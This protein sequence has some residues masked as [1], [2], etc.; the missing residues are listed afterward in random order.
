MTLSTSKRA[1]PGPGP[2]QWPARWP[3]L[4]RTVGTAFGS[5]LALTL[6]TCGC[7]F[8]ALAGPALSLHTRTQA[9][10]QTLAGFPGTTKTVQVSSTLDQVAGALQGGGQ[11]GQPGPA[12]GESALSQS[13]SDIARGLAATPLPLAGGDW[14]GLNTNPL[15]ITA[16]AARS[17][18]AQAPPKME[19]VYR[20][21]F[22][23]YAQLVAGSYS[24]SQ[25]PAGTVAVAATVPTAARFGL[26]PGSR[27]TLNTKS[28]PATIFVTAIVRVRAGGST[29][30]QQDT[31]IVQPSLQQ[32]TLNSPAY[33]LGGVIADP[34]Q[35][36]A[37]QNAFGAIGLEM[38]WEFPLD[39]SGVNA[40]QA[41]GL[42]QA[43]NH[44][45]TTNPTLTALAPAAS[46]LT[47]TSPLIQD[48]ALFLGTQAAVQTVLLIL[49][50]SLI[51]V[52]A[53][54]ILLAARMIV[55]RRE[56]ELT[57][58]RSRGGSLWQVAGLMLRGAVVA[59][60]PGVLVG[61]AL[62]IALVPGGAATAGWPLAAIAIAA[63]LGGP[64]LIAV[65]Q[66]RRPAPA[67]NPARIT[68]AET[69]R[70]AGPA[71]PWR[72][73]VIEVT[74]VA[75]SVAGLVVLRN[76]GV[77][78]G[79]G[80]DLYLTITPVLVAIP[81]VV[82]MVRLYPL[83]IRGLLALS[84]RGAGATGFVA[85]SRAAKSSLT[86]ALPAFALVLALSLATFAGMVNQG[87]SR[88]EVTASWHATGAD[89]LIQPA[90]D[91]VIGP[92]AV[93]AISAVPGV[94]HATEVWATNWFTL[95]GQQVTVIAVDPASYAA[96]V[97]DT[98]FSAFPARKIGQAAPRS[99]VAFGAT[100]PV[101]ASPPALAVLGQGAGQLNS[102]SA[103]G[104]LT[105]RVA[106]VLGD[107]PALPSGGPF[108]VMPL[109]SLPGP[110]GAA[111]PN[112]ILVTGSAI[113]HA[114]LT[115]V[116]NRMIPDNA[117]T[118][119]T[120]VLAALASSPLQHGAGL[121]ITLIIVAAAALGLF[122]VILGL[123]LGSAERGLTL[124]RLTVMGHDRT[125]G[126]VMAEAMPAVIAAVIAGAVCGVV[127]PRVIASAI[128]LSAF[129]GSSTPVQLQ[130]DA[131]ALG[132]PA[133]IIVVLALGALTVEA[134]A[135]RRRDI[136]GMLRAH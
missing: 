115:A 81:V 2:A 15:L 29:F 129:T 65:W 71:R 131:L 32:L 104:P 7:V 125:T 49:F 88:G 10:H 84:A 46:E 48:L 113:N 101:L 30:W 37:I 136:S 27:L 13:T 76:Q 109:L 77:A 72:R 64:P 98:P 17:A 103:M 106:G 44:A 21:P 116:A 86:G 117:I 28:G 4:S 6:L 90:P 40:D 118:F 38:Q 135:L 111:A 50:V 54:V 67:S 34:D 25:A 105:V 36:A 47:V 56:G 45:T 53:A 3:A 12:L 96:V 58:L 79:G 73:P 100:V 121:I 133:A 126:L 128:D 124:A 8:T 122:I 16:G 78:A 9:L 80:T 74:A 18:Y 63:A 112:M 60:G 41:Q 42:Y 59:A 55:A 68:S 110:N 102:L 95:F 61:A 114:R 20:D 130:P 119:R 57:M 23:R 127:L 97:A 26:H 62:A 70:A 123:S 85:L 14:A 51:V 75:A 91:G 93:T 52:G 108:V 66:H 22:T 5:V 43:L 33:W 99:V 69:R 31:T 1:E 24:S 39:V 19:V 94:R 92:D 120:S 87:I 83:A 89:V 11:N 134:R 82:V 35:I 107:T 132:L